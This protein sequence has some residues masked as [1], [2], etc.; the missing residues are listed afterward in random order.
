MAS[1]N[2][3]SSDLQASNLDGKPHSP[4]NLDIKIGSIESLEFVLSC[5]NCVVPLLNVLKEISPVGVRNKTLRLPCPINVIELVAFLLKDFGEE[6]KL[7][8]T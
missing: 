6:Y 1:K 7:H 8:V 3:R 5:R 2:R 4:K